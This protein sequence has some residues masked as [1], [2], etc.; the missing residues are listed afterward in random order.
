MTIPFN[1]VLIFPFNS[2]VVVRTTLQPQEKNKDK[3][4]QQRIMAG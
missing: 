2:I 1:T 3:E 4:I